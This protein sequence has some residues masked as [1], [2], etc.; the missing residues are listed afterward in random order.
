MA[1]S[2]NF[3]WNYTNELSQRSIK[4]RGVFLS[5]Y[6]VQKYTNGS[7]KDLG[8]HGQTVQRIAVEYITRCVQEGAAELAQIRRCTPFASWIPVNT[9]AAQWKSGNCYVEDC[10]IGRMPR[11][12]SV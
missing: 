5:A 4:E 12:S 2:I 10:N 3:V 6:D 1:R 9:G 8:L 11:F 7:G